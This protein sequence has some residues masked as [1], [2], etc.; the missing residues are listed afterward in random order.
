M[1]AVMSF[2]IKLSGVGF[3]ELAPSSDVTEAA[4]DNDSENFRSQSVGAKERC[5][6]HQLRLTLQ[7]LLFV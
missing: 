6:V 4:V 1:N 5:I 3:N 2:I 7:N